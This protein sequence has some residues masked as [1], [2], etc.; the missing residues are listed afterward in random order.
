MAHHGL[1]DELGR[2]KSVAPLRTGPVFAII[3][4]MK[5]LLPY[6]I[7]RTVHCWMFVAA[8]SGAFAGGA[9][10]PAAAGLLPKVEA[11]KDHPYVNSLGMK[12]VP[13]PGTHVLFSIWE[14]RV[15]DFAAFVKETAYDATQ[16]MYSLGTNR[17]K[18]VGD[19][20]NL[21][22]FP[23]TDRHAVCGVS[24]MDANEFCVWLSKK[25]GR[26]YR[27]PSDVEWSATFD[28]TE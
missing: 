16:G 28:G 18:M 9:A 1:G 6:G 25:E 11:T 23:Q 8:L 14:T 7:R 24:W 27:L 4:R 17:W 12:F 20:W 15:G 26:T 3:C 19:T 2:L 13:V 21:P 5:L 10:E 22:G